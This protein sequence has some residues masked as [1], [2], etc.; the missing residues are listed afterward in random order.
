MAAQG[1]GGARVGAGMERVMR[2]DMGEM[3]KR[4][5]GT[6]ATGAEAL[7]GKLGDKFR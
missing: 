3:S 5:L 1:G 2:T 6:L 7:G 4:V